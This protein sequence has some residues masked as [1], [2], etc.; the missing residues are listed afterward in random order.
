MTNNYFLHNKSIPLLTAFVIAAAL[1]L[2]GMR[3]PDLARPHRPKPSQRAVVE[4]QVKNSSHAIKKSLEIVAVVAKPVELRAFEL[5]RTEFPIALLP[6]G[7]PSLFPNSSRAP[8]PF[9]A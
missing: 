4:N 2:A 7:R 6:T 8:P 9:S 3:V 5:Y 1:L